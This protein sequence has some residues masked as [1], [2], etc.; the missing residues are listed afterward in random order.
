MDTGPS[1]SQ[2]NINPELTPVPAVQSPEEIRQ[3]RL[4]IIAL[5]LGGIF[6]LT[7]IVLGTF[8]LVQPTTDVPE[9]V[10]SL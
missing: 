6:L 10:T 9:S 7:L 2:D 1:P 4:M 3:R 5:V 8:Y